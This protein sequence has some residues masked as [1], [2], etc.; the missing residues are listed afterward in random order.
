GDRAGD[1]FDGNTAAELVEALRG[2]AGLDAQIGLDLGAAAGLRGYGGGLGKQ[3]GTALPHGGVEKLPAVDPADFA[4]GG[5]NFDVVV[6]ARKDFD[7]V[8]I[9][10]GVQRLA[11]LCHAAPERDA[12]LTDIFRAQGVMFGAQ[13]PGQQAYDAEQRHRHQQLALHRAIPAGAAL[14]RADSKFA[15][16]IV[17]SEQASCGAV[18][19]V[20]GWTWSEIDDDSFANDC[21]RF[22]GGSWHRPELK[23]EGCRVAVHV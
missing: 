23:R 21:N 14:G 10:Q 15:S 1:N 13:D 19:P 22:P 5:A 20:I 4:G 11:H 2:A 16:S 6:A 18:Q 3:L 8:T 12:A 7:R 9:V 17:C